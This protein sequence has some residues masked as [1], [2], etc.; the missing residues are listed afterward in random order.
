M[1]SMATETMRILLFHHFCWE[2][3]K[4]ENPLPDSFKTM[5]LHNKAHRSL[6]YFVNKHR[7]SSS[8][9]KETVTKE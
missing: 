6:F 1:K 4:P 3:L 9:Q 7:I 5:N 2:C 8:T